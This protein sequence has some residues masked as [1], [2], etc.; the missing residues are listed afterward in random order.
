M[1]LLA[2]VI[3]AISVISPA[4]ANNPP[5]DFI[6]RETAAGIPLV[7][8]SGANPQDS[9]WHID[10]APGTTPAQM[11]QAQA[12]ALAFSWT[13]YPDPNPVAAAAAVQADQNI[14]I[15]VQVQIG[16]FA[17]VLALYPY[18][19]AGVQTYWTNLKAQTPELAPYASAIEDDCL[20]A[21]IV[22]NTANN[23]QNFHI[24]KSKLQVK[25]K[26][27]PKKVK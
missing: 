11:K 7:G 6:A 12:D 25:P 20:T 27:Q 22:L 4:F 19:P 16:S 2:L 21:Y 26:I 14:P 5:A 1:K 8:V 17:G 23:P 9:H 10:G 13:I 15:S 24:A 3:L 18:N